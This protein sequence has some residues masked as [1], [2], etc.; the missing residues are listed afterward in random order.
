[1]A[2]RGS[3]PGDLHV[4]GT[5]SAD[6][7]VYP[8][9][10][11]GGEHIDPTRPIDVLALGQQYSRLVKQNHG[12]AV[13]AR[14]EVVHVAFGAGTII[15]VRAGLVVPN[16][17]GAE[18]TVDLLKNGVSVLGGVVTLD[19]TLAAYDIATAAISTPGYA[20]EDV[21]E[22]VVTATAGGG[23]VGQGLFVHIIFREAAAS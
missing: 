23:T 2:D 12:A 11:V 8:E 5:L 21:F 15:E 13:V 14:R 9:A 6:K 1:M 4:R 10:S 3:W 19:D 22:V 20:A 7:I 16:L 17:A 18:V